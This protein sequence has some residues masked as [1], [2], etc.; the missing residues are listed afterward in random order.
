MD[1]PQ[2]LKDKLNSLPPG[3]L[4]IVDDRVIAGDSSWA[5][6]TRPETVFVFNR[7]HTKEDQ[8]DYLRALIEII[9]EVRALPAAPV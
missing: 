4:R 3:R 1:L 5:P 7:R 6:T 9:N 8:R 2:T